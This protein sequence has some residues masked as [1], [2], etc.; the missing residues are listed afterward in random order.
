MATIARLTASAEALGALTAHLRARAEGIALDPEIG[1]T[2]DRIAMALDVDTSTLDPGQLTIAATTARTYLRQAAD[3][4][5]EPGR[6]IGW[7]EVDADGLQVQGRSSAV[8]A[9]LIA[10][11]APQLAG[12]AE[13]LA[14]PGA[15]F[16]DIGS[17]IGA[18]AVE[19]CQIWP[20]LHVVGLEPWDVP[21][22]L[23]VE[24]VTAAGVGHRVALRTMT[25]EAFDDREAFDAA[26]LSGPFLPTSVV[27]AALARTY[28]A[29]HPGGWAIFGLF[30]GPEGDLARELLR[31]RTLR[32]GG[33]PFTMPEIEKLLEAAGFSDV[34]TVERTCHAPVGFV[35]GRR[36]VA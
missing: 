18:I 8:I 26:W 17:G 16:L 9:H 2:L 20:A 29:L 23:A 13:A 21:M 24:N 19:L 1:D 14:R 11:M 28:A 30:A 12:L 33:N 34:H 25:I 6:P 32:T 31:L 22:A 10:T 35:V 5:E 36:P 15:A 4:A 7:R 27:R 3:L